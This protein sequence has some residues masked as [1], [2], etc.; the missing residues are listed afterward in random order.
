MKIDKILDE[1]VS[2]KRISFDEGVALLKS[3]DIL[4]LG[5]AADE[6][7]RR[8][9]PEDYRT[10]IVDRNINYSNI[11]VSG[12]K[13][14]AFSVQKG[15]ERAYVLTNEELAEKIEKTLSLSGTQILLQGG[16]HPD[17]KLPFYEDM[18]KFPT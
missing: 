2:G 7:T 8:L 18:L 4:S 11:C 16:L 13:F 3:G 17:F 5:E 12:C 14:C 9:H 15:D 6:I 1:A 10:F